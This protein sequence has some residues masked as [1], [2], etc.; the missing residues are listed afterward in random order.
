MDLLY[1]LVWAVFAVHLRSPF[2]GTFTDVNWVA[3]SCP[4]S[5]GFLIRILKAKLNMVC[6]YQSFCVE[7]QNLIVSKSKSL[8]FRFHRWSTDND[9]SWNFS[10]DEAAFGEIAEKIR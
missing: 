10:C 4:F 2:Q 6:F 5:N 8:F 7:T 1:L 3:V 9:D